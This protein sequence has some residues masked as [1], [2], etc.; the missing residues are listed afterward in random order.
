MYVYPFG[1][2]FD[3]TISGNV[4]FASWWNECIRV[5]TAINFWK[6]YYAND[7]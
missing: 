5:P 2:W 6:T 7:S 3:E 4:G 1:S